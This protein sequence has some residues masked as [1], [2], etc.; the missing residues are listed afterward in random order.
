MTP[1]LFSCRLQQTVR[2]TRLFPLNARDVQYNNQAI[3]K[4]QYQHA[5]TSDS[6]LRLYGYTYYSNY[7]A[8]GA[9]SSW[10][11]ISG[12]DSGDYELNSHTRGL[13]ANFTKQ[14]GPKHLVQTQASYVTATSLR[15]NSNQLFGD[16][17]DFAVLV[18]PLRPER[19]EPATAFTIRWRQLRLPTSGTSLS[20][21]VRHRKRC[22]TSAERHLYVARESAWESAYF[23]N[24]IR[25]EWKPSASY[26]GRFE[27][28]KSR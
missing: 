24:A 21:I 18:N 12:L 20:D 10:Q 6:F 3:A 23:R 26:P 19:A 28:S 11:P 14:F 8:A 7:I 1:V 9:A 5:F 2:S 16:A 4:V 27:P 25:C 17:D 13:S 15:M 22:G